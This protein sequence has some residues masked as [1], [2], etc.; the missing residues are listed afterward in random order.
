MMCKQVFPSGDLATRVCLLKFRTIASEKV[1]SNFGVALIQDDHG[2]PI[3]VVTRRISPSSSM[4]VIN[5]DVKIR[6]PSAEVAM[7][8][9]HQQRRQLRVKNTSLGHL[10]DINGKR[11]AAVIRNGVSKEDAEN[12]A[13]S[14]A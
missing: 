2:D 9:Y 3:T 12:V 14:K 8:V 1:R 13:L 10:K 6:F 5:G 11:C 4:W 7:V